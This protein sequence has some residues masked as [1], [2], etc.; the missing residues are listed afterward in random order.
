MP[1]I[2]ETVKKNG[3]CGRWKKKIKKSD[4]LQNAKKE[5]SV[6]ETDAKKEKSV[7]KKSKKRTRKKHSTK[8]SKV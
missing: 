8:T 1:W 2:K 7:K 6:K 3:R 5:E 4:A